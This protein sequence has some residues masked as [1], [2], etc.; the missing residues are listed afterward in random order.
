M[1]LEEAYRGPIVQRR[2]V[3]PFL[4]RYLS[5]ATN[6]ACRQGVR[7]LAVAFNRALGHF[8]QV[9]CGRRVNFERR[10]DLFKRVTRC[11]KARTASMGFQCMAVPIVASAIRDG[12]RDFLQGTRKA[13]IHGRPSS[14]Y[15]FISWGANTSRQDGFFRYVGREVF[16]FVTFR[17]FG[18]NLPVRWIQ[19]FFSGPLW[20]WRYLACGDAVFLTVKVGQAVEGQFFRYQPFLNGISYLRDRAYV[21]G[22]FPCV[23]RYWEEKVRRIFNVRAVVARLIR[24][25]LVNQRVVTPSNVPLARDVRD[26]GRCDFARLAFVRSMFNVAVETSNGGRLWEQVISPRRIRR[27]ARFSRCNFRVHVAFLGF[28]Q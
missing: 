5:V 6:G 13:T 24:R 14:F 2:L 25:G 27:R 18:V 21:F 26:W 23:L 17:R 8:R 1:A 15:F 7:D 16:L 22:A 20:L 28:T 4:R 3:G 9:K 12:G 10:E 11:G 19:V